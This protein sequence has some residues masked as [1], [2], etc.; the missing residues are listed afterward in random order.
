MDHRRWK[1]AATAYL[2]QLAEFHK[3]YLTEVGEELAKQLGSGWKVESRRSFI[4]V[5]NRGLRSEIL[6]TMNLEHFINIEI[7]GT[8]PRFRPID[9][10]VAA[11]APREDASEILR[12]MLRL[13]EVQPISW[14]LG[15]R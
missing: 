1:T 9:L 5:S 11:S 10:D 3:K 15:E 7:H 4:T 12:Y 13:S 8:D 14:A 2:N 6:L